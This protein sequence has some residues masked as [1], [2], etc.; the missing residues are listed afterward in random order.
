MR[1]S[2]GAIVVFAKSPEPGS[3][4]TRMVPPLDARQA[5]QLYAAMLADVLCATAGFARSLGLEPVLCVHPSDARGALARRCPAGFRVI[6]QRGG[7]LASRMTWAAREVAAA[8]APRVL[9]RGSDSPTLDGESVAQLLAALEE[10]DLAVCPDP[11][12]GYSL[13]GLRSV[14]PDLFDHPMSTASVLEDTL[15]NA[16]SAGLRA[17][18]VGS[19]FDLDT[20][21]DLQ[22]LERWRRSPGADTDLCRNTLRYLDE[23]GLWARVGGSGTGPGQG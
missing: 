12:G 1:P 2:R 5:A 22:R 10:I 11:D 17:R 6:G 20:A 18:T 9:L 19:S 23:S 8:G 13:I 21:A 3:V 15:A 4:K 16:A 14:A 7:N